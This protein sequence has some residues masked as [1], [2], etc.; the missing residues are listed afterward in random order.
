MDP[1]GRVTVRLT[2]TPQG[3]GHETVAT[4]IV[5]DELGVPAEHVR[6]IAEM[7]TSV[8][9]WTITTG[10][11]SSRFAPLS[12]SA[13]AMAARKLRA[14]L[15]RI[16]AHTL[17]VDVDDLELVEGDFR[18]REDPENSLPLRAAAGIAHWNSSSLP[19]EIDPGL[20]E[21]GVY[22]LRVTAPPNEE[23]QVDSS[24]CYGFLTDIAVV[25]VD[26]ETYEIRIIDY[27][28]VHDAGRILNPT[29]ADGQIYGA[30]A[31]GIGGTF[32]EE[33][34]YDEDG[35]LVTASFLDYLVPTAMETPRLT[36][37]HIETPSPFSL[38]GAKGLGEGNSMSTPA[39]LANAVSDAM[40][41]LGL[42]IKELPIKPG[43]LYSAVH[44]R[45]E[46]AE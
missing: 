36:I 5:V 35:Q 19:E 15:A 3:Q 21:T 4:Q 6:A 20:Y 26:P 22:S 1:S 24:A 39:A 28:S 23:D 13:V 41:P 9:P 42:S 34:R 27:V 18:V 30:V 37:D 40:H 10:S 38:L 11:Y 16:A 12:A 25:E 33:F 8:L 29:L 46:D 43:T 7:D 14:K 17:D 44:E 32:Y 2:S 45:K 31:H